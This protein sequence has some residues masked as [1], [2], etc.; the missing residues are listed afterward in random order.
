MSFLSMLINN[1]TI[2]FSMVHWFLLFG[3]YIIPQSIMAVEF[4]DCSSG[5]VRQV[6][7]QGC[8]LENG[9][10]LNEATCSLPQ[11]QSLWFRA[12]FVSSKFCLVFL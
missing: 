9:D 6:L 12:L 4:T 10:S 1:F 11:G 3:F 2:N 5:N 8:D 7:I